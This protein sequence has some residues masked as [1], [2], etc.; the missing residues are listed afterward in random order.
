MSL[1]S[2]EDQLAALGAVEEGDLLGQDAGVQ[3]APEPGDDP[4]PDDSLDRDADEA[5]QDP[6]QRDDD[7]DEH[8]A[9]DRR[10]P[11]GGGDGRVDQ[12]V[13]RVGDHQRGDH[14]RRLRDDHEDERQD[15]HAHLRPGHPEEPRDGGLGRFGG[16][17]TGSCFAGMVM[18]WA[19]GLALARL[20]LKRRIGGLLLHVV[21]CCCKRK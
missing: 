8:P 11:L 19:W 6:R 7:G 1:P 10:H 2:R 4:L 5:G 12:E 16:A 3:P 18:A 21:H 15:E 9:V 14:G 17:T 20:M 13:V